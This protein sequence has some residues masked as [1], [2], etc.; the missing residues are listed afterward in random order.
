MK[1][2]DEQRRDH[3]DMTDATRRQ[4][5]Q[6]S[7]KNTEKVIY[8]EQVSLS[9]VLHTYMNVKHCTVHYL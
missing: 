9:I 8:C 1:I 5:N 2:E 4:N 3:N 7:I 6:A